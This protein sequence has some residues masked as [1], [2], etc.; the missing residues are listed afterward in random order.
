MHILTLY[1][2]IP[3]KIICF[4]FLFLSCV[5]FASSDDLKN[6]VKKMDGAELNGKAIRIIDVRIF[7]NLKMGA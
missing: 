1:I 3:K 2:E 5:C 6:M 7:F 4:Y